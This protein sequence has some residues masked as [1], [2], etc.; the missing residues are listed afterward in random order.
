MSLRIVRIFLFFVMMLHFVYRGEACESMCGPVAS[1]RGELAVIRGDS[2]P[3]KTDTTRRKRGMSWLKRIVK[4]FDEY[5]SDYI[6]TN[7]YNY[8]A[9][10]QNTNF[11]QMFRLKAESPA[12]EKQSLT[13]A[14][15]PTFKVGPYFGWRWIFLGYTFDIS[16]LK[17]AGEST[18]FNLSLY[19]SMLGVDLM[20][21]RNAGNFTIRNS[22]GFSED[23][24]DRVKGKKFDGMDAFTTGINLYYVFNHRRFSYPAAFAQSTVQKRSCG[25]FI[26]GLGYLRQR[27]EFDYTRLPEPLNY[28]GLDGSGVLLEEMKLTQ[29]DYSN[30]YISGGY[31]Y[32]WV[33]ARNCLLS[34][35]VSP[36]MGIKLAKGERISGD[37][38][39]KNVKDLSFNC[40]SR[41]GLVWNSS[42]FFAGLSYVNYLHD[43]RRDAF[44]M[45]NMMNYVSF[46]AG[47]YFN[48]KSQ[49]RNK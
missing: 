29:V 48:R 34:V 28:P 40:I 38:I 17:H 6:Q 22:S 5:D 46:Y 35:S 31:A 16:N 27:V 1:S 26:L 15:S 3:A 2:V 13:V 41:L 23:V 11:Y 37:Q 8:T 20:Y 14:P 10:L 25:S 47:F 42:R 33:F 43:Y 44:S 18:E 7:Y 45:L 4:S 30:Y 39:W 32:N 19:S 36:S 24:A 21:I 12:G 9:M 49:Y